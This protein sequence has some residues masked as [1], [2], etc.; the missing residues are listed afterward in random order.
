MSAWFHFLSSDSTDVGTHTHTHR[1]TCTRTH[2]NWRTLC[3]SLRHF[4][5]EY[6][7][8]DS[9]QYFQLSW[10]CLCSE[11]FS[12]SISQVRWGIQVGSSHVGGVFKTQFLTKKPN[13]FWGGNQ[14]QLQQ[15]SVE[16]SCNKCILVATRDAFKCKRE[17]TFKSYYLFR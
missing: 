4:S 9:W 5:A 10:F 6:C 8:P 7:L 12:R 3:L 16:A 13:I 14:S 15:A 2:T 1:H 17:P 11:H